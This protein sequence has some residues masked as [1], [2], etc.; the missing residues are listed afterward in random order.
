M[1]G[2]L[3]LHLLAPSLFWPDPSLDAIYDDLPLPNL[4]GLLAKSARIEEAA[5]PIE[6]WLCRTFHV[7]RQE[8]WPVAPL[9]LE[10][11]SAESIAA[12]DDRWIR[13]DPIHLRIEQNQ[14]LLADSHVFQISA[15]EAQQLTDF[16]NQHFGED[17]RPIELLPLQPDRWYLNATAMPPA[18]THLLSE[19]INQNMAARLPSGTASRQWRTLLNEIQMLLHDHPLNQ[20][21]ERRGEPAVN[22]VWFW[23]GGT[24]PRPA[25]SAYTHVWSDDVLARSL[26]RTARIDH[27]PLPATAELWHR[28]ATSGSH[29]VLLDALYRKSRYGDAYGWREEMKALERDWFEP[30]RLLSRQGKLARLTLTD[31]GTRGAGRFVLT[32]RDWKKFWHRIKPFS[33]YL[34]R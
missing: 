34:P 30:L 13:A 11:D 16:L 31:I 28:S 6:P 23:G 27:A 9:T 4:A 8:D 22:G 10:I 1:T 2:R 25:T 24:L 17:D 26:A 20:S 7:E 29:L 21:R 19:A 15:E 5:Q 18:S 14:I 33:S 3:E 32:H 12:G